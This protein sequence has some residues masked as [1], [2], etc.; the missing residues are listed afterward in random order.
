MNYVLFEKIKPLFLKEVSIMSVKNIARR[1]FTLIELLIVIAII[2]ILAALTV[3]ALR[4]ARETAKKAICIGN[5][6]NLGE[7]IHS[8]VF[9]HAQSLNVLQ[10]YNDWYQRLVIE[11]GG[12]YKD[13]SKSHVKAENLDPTGQGIAKIFKCPADITKGTASYGRNDPSGG[14]T[15]VK[16]KKDPRLVTSRVNDIRTPSDLIIVADRWS[17]KHTPGEAVKND[18]KLGAWPNGGEFDT[19]NAF[20]L[21]YER[22]EGDYDNY[23][24]RHKGTAPILYVD[25]HVTAIDYKQTVKG[26]TIKEINSDMNWTQHAYGS[27]SDDPLLKKK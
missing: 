24:S 26:Y 12:T 1:S 16:G 3:P 25:N 15:M 20:N 5:E 21:R 27:W 11:N 7:Y 19:V 9:N 14:W 8:Y 17:D 6:K 13:T 23:A 4:S 10:N 18:P 2:V 22:A